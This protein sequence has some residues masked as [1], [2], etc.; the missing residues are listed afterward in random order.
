MDSN[1][2]AL[3]QEYVCPTKKKKKYLNMHVRFSITNGFISFSM[4]KMNF[5]SLAKKI[6]ENPQDQ[7]RN[8]IKQFCL[9]WKLMFPLSKPC[10]SL[11]RKQQFCGFFFVL[12]FTFCGFY[13][14]CGIWVTEMVKSLGLLS[15]CSFLSLM[16]CVAVGNVVLIGQNVSLSFEDIEAN[17]GEFSAF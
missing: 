14:I 11:C 16:V 8:P 1:H 4:S 9:R 7:R 12:I 2:L 10:F 15:C 13:Q 5:V 3:K 17:F 6:P